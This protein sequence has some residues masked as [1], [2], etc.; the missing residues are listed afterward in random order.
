MD[1][2]VDGVGL[3]GHP[4]HLDRDHAAYVGHGAVGH[5]S[6]AKALYEAICHV[7]AGLDDHN[8]QGLGHRTSAMQQLAGLGTEVA[9]PCRMRCCGD[10]SSLTDE[11]NAVARCRLM[12]R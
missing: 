9:A 11:K 12:E 5:K 4:V 10:K 2:L 8:L 7:L 6:A 1:V 3:D